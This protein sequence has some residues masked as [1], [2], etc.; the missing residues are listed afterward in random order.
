MPATVHNWD[1]AE[2]VRYPALN[3]HT[4][5]PYRKS[6]LHG[7]F[8]KQSPAEPSNE[9]WLGTL[10]D[11]M[12]LAPE[13][14]VEYTTMPKFEGHHSSNVHKEAKKAWLEANADKKIVGADDWEASQAM[15]RS[16][17]RHEYA[18]AI[19]AAKPQRNQIALTWTDE[20][21]GIECKGLIDVFREVDSKLLWPD[22]PSMD[23]QIVLDVKTTHSITPEGFARE[24]DKF[25]YH[26]QK[27][28]YCDGM[29]QLHE[30]EYV[31]VII[32]VENKPPYDVAVYV[33]SPDTLDAG[34]RLYRRLMQTYIACEKNNYWPGVAERPVTISLPKY[35]R[36]W[37]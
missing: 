12:I 16:V 8:A 7:R 26:G 5:E 27:S 6:P 1:F 3:W 13:R 34:R 25:G 21:T 9:M 22:R 20:I 35:S 24:V 33:I 17:A 32:A 36:D 10:F 2:Y 28:F 18:S 11:T 15:A 14:L 31:S 23:V 37:E 29:W 30:S 4:L 19:L